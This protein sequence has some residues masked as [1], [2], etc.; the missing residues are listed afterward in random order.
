MNTASAIAPRTSRAIGGCSW[1]AP[2][3]LSRSGGETLP[4]AIRS[5]IS[6]AGSDS[7]VDV[8]G[9]GGRHRCGSPAC[10]RHSGDAQSADLWN[11][12]DPGPSA[13]SRLLRPP[14]LSWL[15]R[16]VEKFCG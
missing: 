7:T 8:V 1:S 13:A 3:E 16:G 6:D 9:V 10:H 2:N 15:E 12:L 4:R 14:L 5:V 11:I